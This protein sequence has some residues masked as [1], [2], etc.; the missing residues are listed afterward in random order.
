MIA[1]SCRPSPRSHKSLT[2]F[3]CL[4][5]VLLLTLCYLLLP[6]IHPLKVH[7]ADILTAAVPRDFPPHYSVDS[8]GRPVGFA[9]EV[10]ESVARRAGYDIV[11]TIS[12][13]WEETAALLSQQ[14][15]DCIPNLGVT[16]AR[17]RL[18]AFATPVETFAL[19]LFVRS[20][21]RTAGL[22]EL[23]GRP[24]GA[25]SFNAGHTLLK[26]NDQVEL[27]L[28][29]D[30]R[31]ALMDLLSGSIDGLV[32]PEPVLRKILR[33]SGL[34]DKVRTAGPPLKEIKRS[35]AVHKDNTPLL[36]ELESAVQ[37]FLASGE[38]AAIYAGW[39]ANPPPFW[40]VKRTA[41]SMGMTLVVVTGVMM[42]SRYRSSLHLNSLLKDQISER[43]KIS[44]ALKVLSNCNQT[45]VR[46]EDEATLL[47]TVCRIIVVDGAYR[48]AWIGFARND[49]DKSIEPVAHYGFDEGYLEQLHLVWED[50]PRGRGPV[51]TALRTGKITIIRDVATDPDFEPWRADALERGYGSV[52]SIP[53]QTMAH[54]RI[55]LSI[56]ASGSDAFDQEEIDLL[57]EMAMDLAFGLDAL[58]TRNEHQRAEAQLR[59]NER[60]L[61]TLMSNMPGMAY[62]CRI[63]DSWTMLFVSRGA[64]D[65]TGY[66]SNEL[67][68]NRT[69][70]FGDLIHPDDRE[71]VKQDVLQAV[72]Q[73]Q[74]FQYT[75]RIID[76]SGRQRWVY[77]QG[78][79]VTGP[80]E[81]PHLEGFITDVTERIE[82]TRQL[83]QQLNRISLLN[84]IT[85]AIAE[86]HDLESI[87]RVLVSY[88]E[89]KLPVDFASLWLRDGE[90]GTSTIV[91]NGPSSLDIAQST[92][93][94][95]GTLVRTE[96]PDFTGLFREHGVHVPDT[97]GD[98]SC[99]FFC[100]LAA[101]GVGSLVVHPL[102]EDHKCLGWLIVGR[103][104]TQAFSPGDQEFLRHLCEH[105]AL[106]F[107]QKQLFHDLQKAYDTLRK[108]RDEVMRQERL[109]ALGQMA[110]GIVHDINN[111]LS[112]IVG[113]TDLLLERGFDLGSEKTS[114][115]LSI[116]RTAAGDIVDVITRM[117]SFYRCQEEGR[118]L[119]PVD[120]N[121]I[122]VQ[123]VELT[124]PRWKDIAQH[125]G[126]V[127]HISTDLGDD[128]T[129][130]QGVESELREAVINL[131]INS[132]DALP[133]GGSIRLRT[134]RTDGRILLQVSDTGIGMDEKA[135]S[136]CLEPF[137][138]TKGDK[139][140]GL[141]LAMVYGTTQRHN[142][143]LDI[144]SEPDEGTTISISL[145]EYSREESRPQKNAPARNTTPSLRILCIDDE[146]SL[147]SLA[148]DMLKQ[149]GHRTVSAASGEDGIALFQD[150]KN[151]GDPFDVVITDLGMPY[152]SGEE[153]AERLKSE[154]P[155]TPVILLTG[156][157]QMSTEESKASRVKT[158]YVLRKPPTLQGL[159]K[160][161]SEVLEGAK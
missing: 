80:E 7:A 13:T 57:T 109:R 8:Q 40:T 43:E 50:S 94:L 134:A 95:P 158:D 5:S 49:P 90:G 99:W 135:Q 53:V 143:T 91:A 23:K 1:Q 21:S 26:D 144:Q 9:I 89:N 151:T 142:G 48:L 52:I 128:D 126:K 11:Y 36:A 79:L 12:D 10:M 20:S 56:Y 41:W 138:S 96:E 155:D 154:S 29:P 100:K 149:E 87:F 122:V 67:T 93:L 157:D 150:A 117:R 38:Y 69:R 44:R 152:V 17:Q 86:R 61:Q 156:W 32:Y 111:A 74:P 3:W 65:L 16:K 101:A 70:A 103:T 14:E 160:A 118:K 15:V 110:S 114:K 132:V 39:F 120:V 145:P 146:E 119:L 84:Q 25:V 85:R 137:F 129:I 133:E 148:E 106:A 73:D 64:K 59:E 78:R 45:L 30:L 141:G 47:D 55:A 104:S 131:I 62:R 31:Q 136:Q 76:K 159:R 2:F 161:I 34:E 37:D 6:F 123:A 18:F 54:G 108:T 51:G 75:Y 88:L 125:S 102:R 97:A 130:V 115:Y 22:D 127:I 140:T 71:A 4:Q 66:G 139:G 58:H 63:D 113:Y 42:L 77:E 116:I 112:P 35:I 105:T 72:K 124:R 83:E 81:E 121:Q 82:S 153:V 27:R 60:A 68:L 19:V 147:R 107:R 24:V 28:Y 92:G 33:T 98:T 46:V